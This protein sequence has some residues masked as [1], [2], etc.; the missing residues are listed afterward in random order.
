VQMIPAYSPQAGGR[1]ERNFGT[2]QERLPQEL[3]LA[4]IGELDKANA[5]LRERYIP[6]FN[7]KFHGGGGGGRNRLST[8]H[9]LGP[10]LDLHGAGRACGGQG[11]YGCDHGSQ[12]AIGEEPLPQLTCWLHDDDS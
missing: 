2:W 3:R 7:Q 4:G 10:E 1:S 11:Q 6:V 8:H 9:T 5:F 12:L